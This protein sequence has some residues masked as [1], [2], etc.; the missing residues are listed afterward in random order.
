[1]KHLIMILLASAVTLAYGCTSSDNGVKVITVK[2]FYEAV[3]TDSS[4]VI[5]DVRTAEEYAA[6]HI[7]GAINLNLKDS[8]TFNEGIKALDKDKTY[9]VYCRSGRRSNIAAS[10]MLNAGL[11]AIDMEGGIIAWKDAKMPVAVSAGK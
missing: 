9:Y 1:M 7:E 5:L 8:E 11:K 2:E 3:K 4:A 10:K 6:G